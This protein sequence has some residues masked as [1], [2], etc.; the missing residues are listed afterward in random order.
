MHTGVAVVEFARGHDLPT[1]YIWLLLWGAFKAHF[2]VDVRFAQ[3]VGDS[4]GW[5]KRR[6][7]AVVRDASEAHVPLEVGLAVFLKAFK[8]QSRRGAG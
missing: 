6:Q 3:S 4:G 8:G 7:E 1:P 2:E 5:V